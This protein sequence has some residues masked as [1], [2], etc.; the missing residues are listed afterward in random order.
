MCPTK[1]GI[2]RSCRTSI[3]SVGMPEIGKE[4]S[5]RN[6]VGDLEDLRKHIRALTQAWESDNG[7]IYYSKVPTSVPEDRRVT[8]GARIIDETP[9]AFDDSNVEPV[10]LGE[11]DEKTAGRGNVR[12][13]PT[14][15]PTAP[16][17]PPLQR[18][19]S[20]L[21][22]ELQSKLNAGEDV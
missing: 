2:R 19:D 4:S 12:P 8:K 20:D 9:F 11:P 1:I 5:L 7:S 18:S 17:P 10:K 14:A 16:P 22:R 3:T 6:I 21:A 13:P 15:P